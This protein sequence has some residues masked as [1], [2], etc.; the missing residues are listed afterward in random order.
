MTDPVRRGKRDARAKSLRR[1]VRRILAEWRAGRPAEDCMAEIS[2][3]FQQ[4]AE[5][6]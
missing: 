2:Q 6:R 1:F 4:E 3:R 5:E